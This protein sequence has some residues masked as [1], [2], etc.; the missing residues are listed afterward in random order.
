MFHFAG[1]RM[2]PAG[3]ELIEEAKRRGVSLEDLPYKEPIGI[4][5]FP[6]DPRNEAAIQ[7]RVLAA[8]AEHRNAAINL[9]QTVGIIG[10]LLL[11]LILALWNGHIQSQRESADMMLKFDGMLSAGGS[12]DLLETLDM[13]GNLNR[14]QAPADVV[15]AKIED[16]LDKYELLAAAYRYHLIND[17]MAYDAFSYDL[18]KALKG[19]K[20]RKFITESRSE[21]G[22]IYDGVLEL[23][24]AWRIAFKPIRPAAPA[25]KSQTPR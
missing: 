1:K 18:E 6:D 19:V 25:V 14:V 5:Q 16:L 2:L 10:S 24:Q 23:A 11:T 13:Y 7:S 20:V 3:A 12:G 17:D 21:E 8:R 15:D 9:F 4:K 22:D